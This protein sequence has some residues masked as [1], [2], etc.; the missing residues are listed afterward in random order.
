[1]FVHEADHIPEDS[2]FNRSGLNALGPEQDLHISFTAPSSGKGPFDIVA[3]VST[4]IPP[5]LY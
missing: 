3:T 4:F 2:N 1:M 5:G